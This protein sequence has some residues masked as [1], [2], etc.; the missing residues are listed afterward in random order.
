MQSNV[1][2]PAVA[3]LG[4]F[5]ETTMKAPHK[6]LCRVSRSF[7]FGVIYLAFIGYTADHWPPAYKAL[8]YVLIAAFGLLFLW[9]FVIR[10]FRSGYR[11]DPE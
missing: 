1:L 10:P 8:R 2:G 4:S 9:Y 5:G 7:A 11:G 6:S 3:E